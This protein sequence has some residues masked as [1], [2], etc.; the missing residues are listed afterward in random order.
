M[1][2]NCVTGAGEE[3]CRMS[4]SWCSVV[5]MPTKQ[6]NR[7]KGRCRRCIP[8]RV[9]FGFHCLSD[10]RATGDVTG[11]CRIERDAS[12]TSSGGNRRTTFEGPVNIPDRDA[13]SGH[14]M[15]GV[16]RRP[17]FAFRRR[18]DAFKQVLAV[19]PR[20]YRPP[21]VKYSAALRRL[22]LAASFFHSP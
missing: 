4:H 11:V 9:C 13:R 15:P 7:R 8:T 21:G 5:K 14:L 19:L 10:C 16:R 2:T 6:S 17:V 22:P 3:C 18:S 12:A 20:N 1:A